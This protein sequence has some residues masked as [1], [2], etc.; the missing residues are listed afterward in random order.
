LADKWRSFGWDVREIDGHDHGALY[1]TLAKPGGSQ[2]R[3]I[4]ARTIK[5]KGVSFIENRVEWHHK[6]PSLEQV[7]LALKELAI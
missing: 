4:V 3:C 1:D 7:Q 2:P 6:V 5:G